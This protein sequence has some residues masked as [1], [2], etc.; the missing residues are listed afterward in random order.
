M[1]GAS[2]FPQFACVPVLLLGIIMILVG[3]PNMFHCPNSWLPTWLFVAGMN[4]IIF[5]PLSLF[6]SL[7][8]CVQKN[9]SNSGENVRSRS[10]GIVFLYIDIV[11][12]FVWFA[13][14]CY[15]TWKS[16]DAVLYIN[17]RRILGYKE[18]VWWHFASAAACEGPVLSFSLFVTIFPFMYLMVICSLIWW[19]MHMKTEDPETGNDEEG[20]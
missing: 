5:Y 13:L 17:R 16:V 8:F 15:W 6:F 11:F 1:S 4:I 20:K 19:R 10:W 18:V 7:R 9:N 12:G 2:V 14:G 3:L